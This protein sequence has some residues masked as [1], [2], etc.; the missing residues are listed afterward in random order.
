MHNAKPTVDF[1]FSAE[2]ISFSPAPARR[3]PEVRQVSA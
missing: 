2:K 3:E 1:P